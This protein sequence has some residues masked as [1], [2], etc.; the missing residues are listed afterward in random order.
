MDKTI[1]PILRYKG[2]KARIA[3]WIISHFPPHHTYTELFGGGASILLQK[4]RSNIEIYND[5]DEEVV[6]IFR[7]LQNPETFKQLEHKLKYTPYARSEYNLAFEPCEDNVERA[8]RAILRNQMGFGSR[9]LDRKTGFRCDS[10]GRED[11][12]HFANLIKQ[13]YKYPERLKGVTIENRD[14]FFLF[15]YL[16]AENTL[17][18]VD[19]PYI[20]NERKSTKSSDQYLN[21]MG[22]IE[23]H[24]KLIE[25]L[26]SLKG[27]VILCGY[28]SELYNDLLKDWVLIKKKNYV[29]GNKTE[30]KEPVED[31]IWLSPNTN[32]K[33]EIWN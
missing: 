25:M 26:L 11:S 20:D 30:K 12:Y 4:P 23:E 9:G 24:K 10:E 22:S 33:L 7:V 15:S 5:L 32:K 3:S 14:A 2:G 17:H 13:L 19:P 27:M 16:D 6:N 21:E 8:R 18:L 31:C 1:R 28:E 29:F